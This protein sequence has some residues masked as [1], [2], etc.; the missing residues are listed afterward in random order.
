MAEHTHKLPEHAPERSAEETSAMVD[1]LLSDGTQDALR[2]LAEVFTSDGPAPLQETALERL[3][4]LAD[5]G[6]HEALYR[7]WLMTRHP[8]L[9]V[10]LSEGEW[11][12]EFPAAVKVFRALEAGNTAEIVHGG[13]GLVGPLVEAT[14]DADERIRERAL[15]CLEGLA[16]PDSVDR[17]CEIWAES[18]D[19][20]VAG[21]IFDKGFL[22][23]TPPRVRVLCS[24]LTRNPQAISQ[25]GPEVV[26]PL[27]EA[28]S[29][30]DPALAEIAKTHILCLE[31]QAAIDELCDV[32]ARTRTRDLDAVIVAGKYVASKPARLR[33]LSAIQAGRSDAL[34]LGDPNLIR[35]LVLTASD[36]EASIAEPAHTL[37]L[38]SIES[39]AAQDA[40]CR[41]VIREGTDL[42]REIALSHGYRPLSASDQAI[43][44]FLTE[45]WAEYESLDFDLSLLRDTFEKAGKDLRARISRSARRAGRLELVELVAGV[46][47]RRQMGEMTPREWEVTLGILDG[48][49]DR[50]TLWSLVRR[51]PAVWAVKGLLRLEEVGWQP[52][53]PADREDFL[54]LLRRARR[55]TSEAP[56]LGMVDQ[57]QAQFTAHGGRVTGLIIGSYFEST[58]ASASWD[59]TLRL[60]RMPDGELL[61][62]LKGHA[63]PVNSVAAT[64]DGSVVA[65]GS[66]AEE[67]V[68]LWRAGETVPFRGLPGHLKGVSC[69]SISHDGRL[70]AAGCYDGVCRLWRLSDGVLLHELQGHRRSIRCVAFAPDDRTLATGGDDHGIRLWN[71]PG[72]RRIRELK[73]HSLA[74]R[75]LVFLPSRSML[76]SG[77]ADDQVILWEIPDGNLLKRLTGHDDVVGALA[78]SG[79]GRVLASGSHDRTVRLWVMPEGTPWGTLEKHQ[80][81]VTCL[82]TD[83]E[84]RVL[85]SGSHDCSVMMWNFQSGIF[86]RPTGRPDME[87][88]E[89]LS[90]QPREDGEQQWLDFLLAQM[91]MRWR[92]DIE[93][94]ADRRTVQAGEFDIEV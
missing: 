17:L 90:S 35:P 22:A 91:R 43:F 75:S 2:V 88:I 87:A 49:E 69:L 8:L 19:P 12:P 47:H 74:V 29:D 18:R 48:R 55:C 14:R 50:Q 11:V 38:Q 80:A 20:L 24:L 42:A 15:A 85:V 82:A 76:A 16:D 41:V 94:D 56:I 45:Q 1:E 68:L 26:A 39:P 59:S 63:F 64:P 53:T 79:D 60:W 25:D 51:A 28:M 52:A 83:P 81:A 7:L 10:M 36:K 44:Y 4:T 33:V 46:R 37:L 65:S 21:I 61:T 58:L 32:W 86:R 40:L 71:V 67:K 89:A 30:T 5:Q 72:G 57:P 13:P 70:L 84:S 78:I 73:G 93:V 54:A 66:G 34:D 77:G 31:N 23:R 27:I 62:T 6:H 3:R 9:T 92:Y